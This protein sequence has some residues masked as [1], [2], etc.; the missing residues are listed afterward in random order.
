MSYCARCGKYFSDTRPSDYCPDCEA[1]EAIKVNLKATY[2]EMEP[3]VGWICPVCGRGLSPWTNCCPCKVSSEI[4]I[5][6]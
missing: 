2:V 3:Q 6:Y 1:T 5:T 4:N